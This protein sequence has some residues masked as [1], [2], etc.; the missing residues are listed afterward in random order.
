MEKFLRS[1]SE[2]FMSRES[3]KTEHVLVLVKAAP[4][5]S[6]KYKKYE[7]CTAGIN[8]EEGTWRRLFPF[9]EKLMLEKD[10]KVWDVIELETEKATDDPRFESRKINGESIKTVDRVESQK[11]RREVI[12]R[13]VEGSLETA[14]KQKRSLALIEP[15]IDDFKIDKGTREPL[16][17]TMNGTPFRRNPYGDIRLVYRWRCRERCRFCLGKSH[18]SQCFD[19][20]ANW[21]YRKLLK[22]DDEKNAMIKVRNKLQYEMKYDNNTWFIMGTHRQRPWKKW[23]IVGLLWMKKQEPSNIAPLANFL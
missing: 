3:W 8:P 13:F 20:G 5:W 16:Q 15:L 18:T 11:A 17:F 1:W 6:T 9:S 22:T 19:W 21:L 4:N 7:I 12:K 10:V 14:L 2:L 23:M